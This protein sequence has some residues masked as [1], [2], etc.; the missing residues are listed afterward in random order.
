[1]CKDYL[2]SEKEIIIRKNNTA[3]PTFRV[4]TII[5]LRHAKG[6]RFRIPSSSNKLP[7]KVI[8][9]KTIKY[10][11]FI[12]FLKYNLVN[13]NMDISQ[14]TPKDIAIFDTIK[15]F[16]LELWNVFGDMKK[17]KSFALYVRLV[18]KIKHDD[19]ELVAKII[20]SFKVFIQENETFIASG[21]IDKLISNLVYNNNEKIYVNIHR[22]FIRAN[23]DV[24]DVIK[25][26]LLTINALIFPK[27]ELLD[28]LE[29]EVGS[30]GIDI[31]TP[32]GKYISDAMKQ[33]SSMGDVSDPQQAMMMM[34]SSGMLQNILSGVENKFKSGEFN[35]DR[36][37]K[38]VGSCFGS[39]TGM[40]REEG[41]DPE[42]MVNNMMN[43][44]GV[45]KSKMD[46]SIFNMGE[47]TISEIPELENKDI[48]D[49]D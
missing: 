11:Y 32:E 31:S 21:K 24:Q 19:T 49:V 18:S 46:M 3:V 22:Y 28:A 42:G 36:F 48:Y 37:Q 33:I 43:L 20:T 30:F 45:D 16:L 38:V 26:Y 25:K 9:T 17:E 40:M 4:R 15:E 13:L 39:L 23:S 41:G 1:L 35:K 6:W 12:T 29:K 10:T 34:M 7:K 14:T 44:M 47:T 2:L 8:Y 27:K 5:N